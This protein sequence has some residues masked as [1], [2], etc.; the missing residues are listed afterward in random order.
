[1][2]EPTSKK[3][4]ITAMPS[5]KYVDL[6]LKFNYDKIKQTEF[7][8]ACFNAYLEDDPDFKQFLTKVFADKYGKHEKR[9]RK[10]EKEKLEKHEDNFS[11]DDID[12]IFDIL[13]GEIPEL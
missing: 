2:Y 10:K 7:I 12:D 3:R 9:I 8:R 6:K 4:I 1:M 13:E 5:K 11:T